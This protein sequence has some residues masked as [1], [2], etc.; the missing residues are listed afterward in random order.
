MTPRVVIA[1]LGLAAIALLAPGPA[2]AQAPSAHAAVPTT[3]L[4]LAVAGCNGCQLRLTQAIEG[5]RRVWQSREHTVRDGK[6]AWTVATR[7]TRGMSITVLAP[8]DGG[9]GYVPAVAFRYAGTAPGDAITDATARTERRASA[10]WA[11]TAEEA[12]TL[13]V[14]VVHAHGTNPPGDAIRTPRAFTSVTQPYER[15]M[16]RTWRGI[17]GTQDAIW[18]R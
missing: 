15:P 7:R 18:C 13:P 6:V 5:R 12:V 8:W 14:R 17:V 2:S 16:L 9:A 3:R 4:T 10:C 11:G 1:S